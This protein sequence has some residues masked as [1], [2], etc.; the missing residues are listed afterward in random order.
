MKSAQQALATAISLIVGRV[1]NAA[2]QASQRLDI[3]CEI[4]N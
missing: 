1:A 3:H 2:E 4:D